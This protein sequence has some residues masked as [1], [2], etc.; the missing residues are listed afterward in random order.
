MPHSA[1]N[2]TV[3]PGPGDAENVGDR[4][5]RWRFRRVPPYPHMSFGC[6]PILNAPTTVGLHADKIHSTTSQGRGQAA[7]STAEQVHS[8]HSFSTVVITS[9]SPSQC[10]ILS[11]CF[12]QPSGSTAVEHPSNMYRTGSAQSQYLESGKCAVS[13][14]E[15]N[16]VGHSSVVAPDR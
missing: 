9:G 2:R 1:A 3:R 14:Y 8:S 16:S 5:S 11:Q 7:S 15:T 6:V 12:A 10:V 4:G 13:F